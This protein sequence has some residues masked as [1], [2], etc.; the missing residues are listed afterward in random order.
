MARIPSSAPSSALAG[1]PQGHLS[2]KQHLIWEW[3]WHQPTRKDRWHIS[4]HLYT[5]VEACLS[6]YCREKEWVK[7]QWVKAGMCWFWF[8]IFSFSLYFT[9]LPPS[10]PSLHF[11]VCVIVYADQAQPVHCWLKI[12]CTRRLDVFLDKTSEFVFN[13]FLVLGNAILKYI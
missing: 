3:G 2:H 8:F 12:H 13:H 11:F 5:I 6:N 10:F 1:T 4:L 9:Q 7:T